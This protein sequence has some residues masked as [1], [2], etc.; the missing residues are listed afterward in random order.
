MRLDHRF[1]TAG[2]QRRQPG[3]ATGGIRDSIEQFRKKLEAVTE[4]E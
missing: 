2:Q 3:R 4:G 1:R